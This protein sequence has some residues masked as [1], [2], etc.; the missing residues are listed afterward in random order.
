MRKLLELFDRAIGDIEDGLLSFYLNTLL[1]SGLVPRLLRRQL[2]RPCF[3]HVGTANIYSG[4]VFVGRRVSFGDR[5]MVNHGCLF[6]AKHCTIIL[7]DDV[8]VGHQ[9]SFIT[10]THAIGAADRR[11]G[12]LEYAPIRV[13]SGAW[14]GARAI[15][16]PGVCVGR[17]AVVAAGSVV[18]RDV[19][20][21]TVVAG[22]PSRPIR[23][24]DPTST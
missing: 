23:K 7:E 15:L 12:S 5:V 14:I 2:L 18:T 3:D 19:P 20:A 4:H 11:A 9:S 22:C 16:L 8:A 21:H 13:E 6:D 1:G 24:L 17:G 10:T